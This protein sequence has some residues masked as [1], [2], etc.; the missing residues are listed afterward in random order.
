MEYHPPHPA[1]SPKKKHYL[2]LK[3]GQMFREKRGTA[4]RSYQNLS[5]ASSAMAG[6]QTRY[7]ATFRADRDGYGQSHR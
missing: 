4:R 1:G 7:T 3:H 6:G 5:Q 2:L